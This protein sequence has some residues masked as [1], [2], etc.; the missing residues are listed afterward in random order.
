MRVSST[1]MHQSL[2]HYTD[3]FSNQQPWILP[4]RGPMLQARMHTTQNSNRATHRMSWTLKRNVTP[5]S[6]IDTLLCTILSNH[7]EQWHCY[8]LA[9]PAEPHHPLSSH[10]R[11]GFI[12][13]AVARFLKTGMSLRCAICGKAPD[14]DDAAHLAAEKEDSGTVQLHKRTCQVAAWL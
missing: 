3:H 4:F 2:Q 9:C 5:P 8:A 10:T 12:A 11:I 14:V 13:S 6:W 7:P 1:A